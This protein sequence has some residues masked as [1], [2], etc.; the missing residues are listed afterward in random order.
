MGMNLCLYKFVV[1]KPVEQEDFDSIRYQGD[2]DFASTQ[3]FEKVYKSISG[4]PDEDL[5]WRPVN[6]S[7]AREWVVSQ[8]VEDNQ[9]RL[10]SVLARIEKDESL[11]LFNSW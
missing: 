5:Y 7:L 6:F 2:R 3:D 11:W 8:V 1:G 4:S 9:D 10:L